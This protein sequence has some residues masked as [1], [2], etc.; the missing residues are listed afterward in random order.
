MKTTPRNPFLFSL[1]LM[2]VLAT[3]SRADLRGPYTGDVHSPY[4]F[5]LDEAAGAS[6]A[7]NSGNSGFNAIAFDGNP[8]TAGAAPYTAAQPASTTVLGASGLTGFGNAADPRGGGTVTD[9][10]I[11]VDANNSGGFQLG[12]NSGTTG[13]SPDRVTQAS[14]SGNNG[15]F[16]LEAMV[17]LPSLA[18]GNGQEII[19]T[20][21]SLNANRGFQFRIN[22]AG[23][24]EFNFIS[25]T[26]GAVIEP[27]PSSGDHAFV[28]NEWFH[29]AA[30]YDGV[31]GTISLYWTR[32][33]ATIT[34]ANLLVSQTEM[35]GGAEVTPLIIGNEARGTSSEGFQGLIDEVRISRIP[36][37]AND[38]LFFLDAEAVPDGLDDN[39]ELANFGNLNEIDTDTDGDGFIN[40]VEEAAGS[41]P[42]IKTSVPDDTD[43]DG[44]SDVFEYNAFGNLDT[45]GA[46]DNDGDLVNNADEAAAGTN[47]NDRFSFPDTENG[48]G[49]GLN[50]A[51]ENLYFG[52]LDSGPFDDND[53]DGFVNTIEYDDDTA[54]DDATSNT[55]D[56]ADSDGLVDAFEINY[57]PDFNETPG[58]MGDGDG[59]TNLEEQNAGSDPTNPDSTPADADGDGMP[60]SGNV[61]Q[62]YTV[63]SNTLH[64]WHLDEV[65]GKTMDS[66]PGGTNLYYMV[67]G[68]TM[69][70]PTVA[71]FKTGLNASAGRGANFAAVLSALKPSL[72]AGDDITL[73]YAGA[74]GAFTYE[75]I[76]RI[77]FDPTVVQ[78][79]GFQSKAMQIVSG[80][81]DGTTDRI[82][83]FRIVPMGDTN[84]GAAPVLEFINVHGQTPVQSIRAL[85]PTGAD[86]NAIEQGG[87]YHVAAAYNGNEGTADNLKLY[88]TAL[89]P[90]K[91]SADLLLS[92]QMNDDL[93]ENG[94]CDFAIGNTGRLV[95]AE[96]FVGL[97]DEVRISN[98]ARSAYDFLW[99]GGETPDD[100]DDAWELA[101][102]GSLNQ[103]N[104]GDFDNDGTNN[105]TEFLLN[106]NPTSG[107]S[108]FAATVSAGG[109]TL[110][111]PSAEGISFDIERST[112]LTGTWLK[113]DTVVGAAAQT[114]ASFSDPNPP[115]GGKAFYRVVL[116]TP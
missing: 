6:V 93:L 49:D 7:S 11:G 9:L 68:A 59:A 2:P 80:E 62:P 46:A 33:S 13:N 21:S 5:H 107:S 42:G 108:R 8:N 81:T 114:T 109:S 47:P 104:Q 31:E 88:W 20:D 29:V 54:P 26:A 111:W 48:A 115:T 89:D 112:T 66:V 16:T 64:L 45:D 19:C 1:L 110:A 105:I 91:A 36:R 103:T 69:W 92:A 43:G 98:I 113:I 50:D 32:V 85:L 102:F 106:L 53:N 70:D 71:G 39:W 87:W 57:F 55:S 65:A 27:V 63:D 73:P 14:F 97:I 100:L 58:G 44:L 4:L 28:A 77:G 74:D 15:S 37:A 38:F 56:L 95:A 75:A 18:T 35:P 84:T 24:L 41:D 96:N 3:A 94:T 86:A 99:V 23:D 22:G 101:N 83:Q 12:Q 52:N 116:H 25:G 78:P 10:C 40:S 90:A 82:W 60:D 67:S 76:V 61:L 17:N 30:V 72:A 51:W 79:N 34:E